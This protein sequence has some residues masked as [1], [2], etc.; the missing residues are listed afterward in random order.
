MTKSRSAFVSMLGGLVSLDGLEALSSMVVI[1][2]IPAGLVRYFVAT[3]REARDREQATYDALDA[4]FVRFHRLCFDNPAL[5]IDDGTREVGERSPS[6]EDEVQRRAAFTILLSLFERAFLMY[7]D[8]SDAVRQQ[9]WKG[10]DEYF[11]DYLN[12][13][14]FRQAA[15]SLSAYWDIRFQGY[16]RQALGAHDSVRAVA[17]SEP[18]LRNKVP[19]RS[20]AAQSEPGAGVHAR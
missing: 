1:L 18:S 13:P 2:G 12:N 11:R 9:Q 16:L 8:H 5:G 17:E 14:Y 7:S 19:S 4:N 6:A 20:M 15:A 10:W 3:R